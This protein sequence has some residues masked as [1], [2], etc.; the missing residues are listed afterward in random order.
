MGFEQTEWVWM[1]GRCVRWQDATAHVS[2]HALHYGSGVFEGLRCYQTAAGPAVLRL[3]AHLDRLYASADAYRMAIPFSHDELAGAICDTIRRNGFS[4]CY[5]RPI[6][7]LGSSSLGVHPR[8]CPVEV[9]ILTWPWGAYLGEEALTCGARITI[10]PWRKFHSHMMPT[11][12][13]A[14]GQYLNSVLAVR[15]AAGRGFDEALLLDQ[16]GNIAEGSGENIFLVSGNK[17]ITNDERDSIL[18]GITRSCVLRIASDLGWEIEQRSLTVED[19]LHCDE[20]FFTGTAAEVVPIS[21]IDGTPVG[22]GY[23]GPR[24]AIVQGIYSAATSGKDARYRDW[25]YPVEQKKKAAVA[26]A[27][28]AQENAS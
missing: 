25:L 22:S 15:D 7:Y 8:D 10:S 21:E 5:V 9:A 12:A 14:C 20:A 2:S 6:C 16:D 4:D 1:N 27:A 3:D 23:R 17:L 18:M 28:A 11:T 26:A 24:T 19:L 13:K